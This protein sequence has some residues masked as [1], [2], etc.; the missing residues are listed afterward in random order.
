M[1]QAEHG[2]WTWALAGGQALCTSVHTAIK[3]DAG[4]K[5]GITMTHGHGSTWGFTCPAS[6]LLQQPWLL[7]QDKSGLQF[8]N[9]MRKVLGSSAT[10]S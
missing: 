10:Q 1:T 5:D 4:G 8:Q 7:S 3:Q 2:L 6:F 9:T